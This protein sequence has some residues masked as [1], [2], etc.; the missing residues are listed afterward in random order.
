MER[1]TGSAQ[2]IF[3]APLRLTYGERLEEKKKKEKKNGFSKATY[4]INFFFVPK[5]IPL[6]SLTTCDTLSRLQTEWRHG[7]K[8]RLRPTEMLWPSYKIIWSARPQITTQLC[9]LP[10]ATTIIFI[11]KGPADGCSDA[12]QLSYICQ[13]Q[14]TWAQPCVEETGKPKSHVISLIWHNNGMEHKHFHWVFTV[15]SGVWEVR[16]RRKKSQGDSG[17]LSS[18][19]TYGRE[20]SMGN[21]YWHTI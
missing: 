5:C 17:E 10:T 4:F 21:E 9:Y 7:S 16:E 2:M 15:C 6:S 3:P 13:V 19:C 11:C 12:I 18:V 8:T 1:K 20:N 14:N